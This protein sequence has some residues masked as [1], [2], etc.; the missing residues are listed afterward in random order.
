VDSNSTVEFYINLLSNT[1]N[2]SSFC[3]WREL[4]AHDWEG[5][6]S[7]L[8]VKRGANGVA[9]CCV[10]RLYRLCISVA[11]VT[12]SVRRNLNLMKICRF[13]H[14]NTGV[15]NS[16]WWT[17]Q[18]VWDKLHDQILD[19]KIWIPFVWQC[20]LLAILRRHALLRQLMEHLEIYDPK[21]HI[22]WIFTESTSLFLR[23]RLTYNSTSR[24]TKSTLTAH[25]IFVLLS[26]LGRVE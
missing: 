6:K 14:C 26:S 2:E 25:P 17:L 18:L 4:D 13:I 21:R 8:R 16:F 20:I 10:N 1:W 9:L 7:T 12:H 3:F 5:W 19:K 23:G 24:F 22:I 15:Y 11:V